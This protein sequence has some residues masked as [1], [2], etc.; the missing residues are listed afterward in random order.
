VLLLFVAFTG[1]AMAFSAPVYASLNA[2]FGSTAPLRPTV[3]QIDS[4]STNVNWQLVLQSVS[5][6]FPDGEARE[7]SIPKFAGEPLTVRLRNAGEL[8]PNGR[9]Y[10][11]LNPGNGEVHERINALETGIGPAIGNSLYPI[12]SGKTNWPGHRLALS[13][14]SI[15]LLFIAASGSYL[16][17]SRIRG[18][19]F[20]NAIAKRSKRNG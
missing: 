4:R 3:R 2:I 9:S 17:L 5:T 15:S 12:H 7:L 14:L 1:I 16:A 19:A 13:L 6:E 8:H 11:V 18:G 10:L 20:R